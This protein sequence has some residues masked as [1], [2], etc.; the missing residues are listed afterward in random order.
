MRSR[1]APV[2]IRLMLA[3]SALAGGSCMFHQT[4]PHPTSRASRRDAI[5]R[6]QVWQETDIASKDLVNG[7]QGTGAFVG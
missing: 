3:C 5:A 2:W 1:S 6:A 7:P 4:S